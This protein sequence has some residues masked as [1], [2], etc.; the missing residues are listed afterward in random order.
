MILVLY[1]LDFLL[2]NQGQELEKYYNYNH[3]NF[4]LSHVFIYI[5]FMFVEIFTL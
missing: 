2:W 4:D 1:L 3:N 5:K